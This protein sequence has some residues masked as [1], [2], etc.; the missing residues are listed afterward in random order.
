MK[1][2][3]LTV[4]AIAY[5]FSNLIAQP[6]VDTKAKEILDAVS[7]K[8][9]TYTSISIDFSYTMENTKQKVNDSQS[10]TLI[11]KDK[12]YCLEFSKQKVFSDGKTVWTYLKDSKEMHVDN[13]SVSDDAINPQTIFTLWEKGYKYKLIAEEKHGNVIAQVIDLFPIKG[14][15]FF[16]V[17][18]LID[19]VKKQVMSATVYDKNG[20]IYTYKVGKFLTNTPIND[21]IFTFNKAS[22]PN[23]ELID[24]R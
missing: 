1:R 19:K 12:K 21:N 4:L 18:L 3:F 5:S 16:K 23:V 17:R 14:K 8:T 9:K 15:S 6:Q 24:L 22:Y 11:L 10:G 2:I 13:P 7:A 20:N